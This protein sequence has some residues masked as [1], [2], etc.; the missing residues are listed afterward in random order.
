VVIDGCKIEMSA[1]ELHAKVHSPLRM[2]TD[3][4]Q[5][6]YR[7]TDS[8]GPLRVL[9]VLLSLEIG[10]MEQ[11]VVDLA[12]LSREHGQ[13][14]EVLCLE[15]PG[16]LAQQLLADG[17]PVHCLQKQPGL[18]F[19]LRRRIGDLI[20]QIQPDIVHT[21]QIGCL[22]YA[23]PPARRHGVK[24]IVHTEHGKEYNGRRRT[25]WLG[26]YA[27][28]SVSKFC[29]VSE[30]TADHVAENGIIR[31]D[32][33]TVIYNGIDVDRFGDATRF[34]D[35]MRQ[36]LGIP[37]D[38]FV[39]GTVGR[40]SEIK[41]QDVLIEAFSRFAANDSDSHLLLVGDGPQRAFLTRLTADLKMTSRV[42]FTGYQSQRDKYLAAMDL[43]TLTS[44][45]E[46]TP[47]ALLE[48]WAVGLPVVVTAVGGLP[49]LVSENVTG[50]LVPPAD[51]LKLAQVFLE[52]KLASELRVQVGLEGQA[53]AR[54]RFDR[55]SMAKQYNTLYR[56]LSR[57]K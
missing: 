13:R 47:L 11:V 52:M 34:R 32:Q 14:A 20:E 10:G 31:R 5:V 44:D 48:A 40:L 26:W 51:A 6:D 39:I 38:A 30:N 1:M 22:F 9:H 45:S 46:G 25:R 17:I 18:Q 55:R 56:D 43:F 53:I 24:A 54:T 19:G 57:S 15:R 42:H 28:R 16:E 2:K 50:R 29:C 21:H 8:H 49:E 4:Q 27:A 3:R 35:Q 37:L 36:E 41:R 7:P 23:G 33:I 12:R